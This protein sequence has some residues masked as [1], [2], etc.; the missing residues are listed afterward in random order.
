VADPKKTESS[1]LPKRCGERVAQARIAA[2][3][4]IVPL[5][6]KSVLEANKGGIGEMALHPWGL[7]VIVGTKV[8]IIPSASVTSAVL[9]PEE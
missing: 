5:P 9:A 1:L 6:P 4:A 3:A 7:A 8:V 2:E